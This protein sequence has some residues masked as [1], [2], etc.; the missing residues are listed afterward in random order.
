MKSFCQRAAV[1]F[2]MTL[3][4]AVSTASSQNATPAGSDAAVQSILCR[5]LDV[6]TDPKTAVTVVLFH[7]ATKANGPALGVLLN[8]NDG[9]SVEFLTVRRTAAFGHALSSRHLFRPRSASVLLGDCSS[10]YSRAVFH[11][12]CSARLTPRTARN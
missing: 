2:A 7:Q 6:K 3:G 10:E 4:A 11:P 8:G 12:G 9:A 1:A 5:A